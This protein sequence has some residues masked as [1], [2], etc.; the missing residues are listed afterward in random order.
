MQQLKDIESL[1]EIDGIAQMLPESRNACFL[2]N[3]DA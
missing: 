2:A 3:K 1:S